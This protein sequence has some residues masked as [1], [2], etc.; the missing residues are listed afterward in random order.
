MTVARSN[1]GRRQNGIIEDDSRRTTAMFNGAGGPPTTYW[2]RRRRPTGSVLFVCPIRL[3]R[4]K[5]WLVTNAPAS[6]QTARVDQ[7]GHG[8]PYDC[9]GRRRLHHR[10]QPARPLLAAT[11]GS[12]REA[13]GESELQLHAGRFV[14]AAA[15][16]WH[17]LHV[18]FER[19]STIND[20]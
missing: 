4:Q 3:L 18:A 15:V 14:C 17:P 11:T 6:R 20:E 19:R 5:N 12:Q 8:Q 16:R 7:S 9:R 13:C 1:S 2:K 10:S